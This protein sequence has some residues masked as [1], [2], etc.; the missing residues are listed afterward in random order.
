MID[1]PEYVIHDA[2]IDFGVQHIE[3][4]LS[5]KNAVLLQ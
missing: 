3:G 5:A 1:T 4:T 2:C